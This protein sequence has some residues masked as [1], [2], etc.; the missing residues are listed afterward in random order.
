MVPGEGR[1]RKLNSELAN[2][3]LAAGRKR[4]LRV[5]TTGRSLER[6]DFF[7]A[8]KCCADGEESQ[9]TKN[10]FFR[11]TLPLGAME[12]DNDGQARILLS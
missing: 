8:W 11:D 3:R 7:V 1:N 2:G 10:S 4:A 6:T 9:K 12:R 5:V